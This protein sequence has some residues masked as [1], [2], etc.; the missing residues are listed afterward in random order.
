MGEKLKNDKE[1][2]SGD[3]SCMII[4]ATDAPITSRNL[5]RLAKRAIFGVARTGGHCSNGSGEYVV[6]F[7]TAKDL[8][9]PYYSS[10]NDFLENKELR[11]DKMTPLFEAVIEATEEAIL[12]SLFMAKTITGKNSLTIEKI[13]VE[14]VIRILKYHNVLK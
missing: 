1:L 3:G 2:N 9:I 10:E 12:N 6:A 11:N 7:S 5:K 4:V 14:K 8:R 13:P